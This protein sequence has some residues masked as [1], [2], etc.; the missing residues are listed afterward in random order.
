M[1]ATKRRDLRIGPVTVPGLVLLVTRWSAGVGLVASI[2]AVVLLGFGW[3]SDLRFLTGAL[4]VTLIG[5]VEMVAETAL[6]LEE[7]ERKSDRILARE[8]VRVRPLTDCVRDL[9]RDLESL[10]GAQE[11][12]LRFLGLGF[13]EGQQYVRDLLKSE[14][15]EAHLIFEILLID[16]D[17]AG[18]RPATALSKSLGSWASQ[19]ARSIE[20]IE[21]ALDLIEKK[22]PRLRR[23][24]TI[25]RYSEVP[26]IHGFAITRPLQVTYYS[27]CRWE[28]E[29]SYGWGSTA[30]RTLRGSDAL[31]DPSTPA[32]DD[33]RVFDSFFEHLWKVA[34]EPQLERT[35]NGSAGSPIT[36]TGS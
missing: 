12:V 5:L 21:E 6:R 8:A 19:A 18:R 9:K 17:A 1:S 13:R 23:S 3:V 33:G 30:Y 16:S 36:S 22:R 32:A 35:V 2:G 31:A 26:F 27:F 14:A 10:R 15:S 29:G 25:K 4:S 11:I 20:Q 7:V 28:D 24:V 34:G